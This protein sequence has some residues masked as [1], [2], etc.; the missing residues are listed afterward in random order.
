M[1]SRRT[2]S[3]LAVALVALVALAAAAGVVSRP[4]VARAT[5]LDDQMTT[6]LIALQAGVEKSAAASMYVYPAAGKVTPDGGL[7]IDFWPR[8]PWT[9]QAMT[10]GDTRGHYSYARTAQRR[11]YEL[12]GYLGDGR[13][14][15]VRGRMPY[16]PTLAYDHRGKEGLSLI[17]QYVRMWS[18][19]HGGRLPE[20][21]QV[22]QTGDVGRQP[23]AFVWPSN[24][25]DHRAMQQR[26]DR[27][28]FAYRRSDDSATFTLTLHMV[29]RPDYVLKGRAFT[30]S[31]V[32]VP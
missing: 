31:A 11:G 7:R 21:D 30:A 15:T 32:R 17:F 1:P 5:T 2:S 27:G 8:D 13:T 6:C 23:Y 20:P 26:D 29:T 3:I 28:S 14:F 9:G 22:A 16:T 10:P 19:A 18:L 12:T 24:P 4:A 25:W